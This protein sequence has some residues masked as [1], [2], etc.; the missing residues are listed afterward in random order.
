MLLVIGADTDMFDSNDWTL[1]SL[2]MRHKSDVVLVA[3]C[4]D[5]NVPCGPCKLPV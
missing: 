1:L 5:V 2:A 4:A 3:A